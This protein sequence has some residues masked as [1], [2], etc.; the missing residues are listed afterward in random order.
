MKKLNYL[1]II[2]ILGTVIAITGI[3]MF[4]AFITACLYGEKEQMTIF[5]L[6]MICTTLF[7]IVTVII[8]H[9]VSLTLK[10]REGYLVV[11]LSWV[12]ASL[13]GAIPFALS[14]Y[15]VSFVDALFESTAGFT[16]TGCSVLNIEIMPR[17]LII[18]KAIEHWLGGMGILVFMISL[19]PTLG[20][21]GQK[22]IKAEVPGPTLNKMGTRISGSAKSLY[23]IYIGFSIVEFILLSF[24]SMGI[25]D[26]LVNTMSS[27][28]TSGLLTTKQSLIY[29]DSTYI[30]IVISIFTILASINFVLYGYLLRG[31]WKDFFAN[32]ELKG[33]LFI[34][35][36]AFILVTLGL[37]ATGT[38]DSLLIS[39][40]NSFFQTTAFIST[41]G[42][43]ITDY[44]VWPTFCKT[45]IFSLMFIGGCGTSTA[46]S[47]KIMRV[48]VFF[49]LI[50]RGIYKKI[51]P[52]AVTPVK[53]GNEI[54]SSD[55][56]TSIT[57][58]ILTYFVVFLF[59][60]LI[61]SLQNLDLMTTLSSAAAALSNTGIG[62]GQLGIT[63]DFSMYSPILRLFL[64]FLMLLGRLEIFTVLVLF[65]PSFWK[66]K[67]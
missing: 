52:R 37:Y 22:I 4:P 7:G 2:K 19:I 55:N 27:I 51:H 57:T 6:C 32:V 44:S 28:S 1:V 18:W 25:F 5:F 3:A 30:E 11:T 62:F 46:G 24:S 17:S 12:L 15:V 41:S 35:S 45:I 16:T 58:Y 60:A 61:L 33:F 34:L 66:D 63:A 20:I 26:A 49:R 67:K 43:T 23:L 38:Y 40:K 47:I 31:R 42:Y 59:S 53:I 29:F 21:N 36:I 54:I 56:V 14:S 13:F 64:A 9:P 10:L 48:L 39:M 65:M 50:I 8:T